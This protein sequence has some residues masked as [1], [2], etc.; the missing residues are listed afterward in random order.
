M[1]QQQKIFCHNEFGLKQGY[2]LCKLL[3]YCFVLSR[4]LMQ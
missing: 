1:D 3:S 4:L 2:S